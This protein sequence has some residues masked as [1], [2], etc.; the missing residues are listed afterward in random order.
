[1]LL[2]LTLL[3]ASFGLCSL[4][5]PLAG[6]LARRCGLVDRPDARRKLHER[7]IPLAGGLAVLTSACLV[8][9][10]AFLARHPFQ[11][12]LAERPFA[13]LGLFL[14]CLCLC[15][16]GVFDDLRCL[17]GRH[18]LLGQILAVGIVMAFGVRVQH[19][20]LFGWDLELGYWGWPLT[21]LWLLGAINSL[22][23]LDGMDGMLGCVGAI[24][25]LA[26]AG[27]AVLAG[28][29]AAACV[30]VALAGSLLGFLRSNLPPASVFMG[31]SGSMVV[32]LVIGVLGIQTSLKGPATVALV[33]PLAVLTIPFFDT[34]AAV[35]RRKLTGRSIYATDRGHL[36]HCLLRRGYPRWVVLLLASGFC[37]VT[38]LGALASLALKNELLAVCSALTVIAVLVVTRLFGHSELVLV[39]QR[40]TRLV[41]SWLRPR[42][43]GQARQSEIRLQGT[44]NWKELLDLV[45]ARAGELNLQGVR[46]D[47]NA[48]ALHEE[49]HAQWDA[50]EAEVDEI[51]WRSEMPLTLGGRVLGRL[52]VAGY[53]DGDPVWAKL[54]E[55][56]RLI[57]NFKRS[58]FPTCAVDVP[59]PVVEAREVAAAPDLLERVGA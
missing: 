41:C 31:D 2:L 29:W 26:L 21:L 58:A 10:A 57:E 16:V 20:V 37:G 36:H 34:F 42:R 4:L 54:I 38:V 19:L 40:L 17:R 48:P 13:L 43:E 55:V 53:P 6:L 24:L 23:L 50:C 5:T 44:T 45:T 30:A 27:M 15:V 8:L 14:S 32:G 49:Y 47:V 33:A 12:L 9:G 22:N 7:P 25:T 11:D 35:V 18:K 56:T 51:L 28:Q 1:M 3:A 59:E 39:Q 46:L 52:E